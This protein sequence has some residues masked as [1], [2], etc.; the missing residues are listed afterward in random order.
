M[1]NFQKAPVSQIDNIQQNIPIGKSS[2][3]PLASY[4]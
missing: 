2:A 4:V 1:N 3:D